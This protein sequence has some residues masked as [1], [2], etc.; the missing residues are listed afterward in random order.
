MMSAL[1]WFFLSPLLKWLGMSGIIGC[2]GIAIYLLAPRFPA[3]F[4]VNFERLRNLAGAVGVG[5]FVVGGFFWYAFHSGENYFA[6][7][8]AAKDQAAVQRVG[9]ALVEVNACGEDWDQSTGTC[10]KGSF[11]K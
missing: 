5:A 11:L 7:R 1:Y 2:A 10:K 4:P 3:W 8:I 6:Q 9:E